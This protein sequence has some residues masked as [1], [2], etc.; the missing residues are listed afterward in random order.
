MKKLKLL[1]KGLTL[2][3]VLF[4]CIENFAAIVSDNDGSAFITKAEFDSLKNNF[5]SQIDQYNTSI[6]AKIDGAIAAY[7]AG[8]KLSSKFELDLDN[9]C[10]YTFPLVML[11][12]EK[13]NNPESEYF[14]VSI[15]KIQ[16]EEH[17]LK[18][19][20]IGANGAPRTIVSTGADLGYWDISS[21]P[22]M[23]SSSESFLGLAFQKVKK[24]FSFDGQ[25]GDLN[26]LKESSLRR[27]IGGTNRKVYKLDIEGK[28][29]YGLVYFNGVTIEDEFDSGY[30]MTTLYRVYPSYHFIGFSNS[31]LNKKRSPY[32]YNWLGSASRPVWTMDNLPVYRTGF[33]ASQDH[34]PLIL[35][36]CHNLNEVITAINNAYVSDTTLY[37]IWDERDYEVK[38]PTSAHIEWE[39]QG[40]RKYCYSGTARMP[41]QFENRFNLNVIPTTDASKVSLTACDGPYYYGTEWYIVKWRNV[42]SIADAPRPWYQIWPQFVVTD[43]NSFDWESSD[44]F[45]MIRASCVAYNDKDGETHYMD[46]GMYL[47]KMDRAGTVYFT[48]KF[49]SS[50]DKNIKFAVSKKP[51]S[52]DAN[53]DDKIAFE[54]TN[55]STGA[56][57]SVEKG[58]DATIVSNNIYTI[59]VSNIEK[60]DRLYLYW[61]P[62]DDSAYVEL[63]SFSDYYLE[64]DN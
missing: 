24:N 45:S 48:I 36:E 6:D 16:V 12:D 33:S 8:V 53:N 42:N 29:Q 28:G 17:S 37:N 22:N 60:S 31:Q 54:Y 40:Q 47:G 35:P 63:E 19:K 58:N 49:N 11:Q 7:L 23:Y 4:L 25:V 39:R 26:I 59:K 44:D 57:G 55:S 27:N 61:E 2:F 62:Q 15:P 1:K 34:T 10:H 14:N 46:E 32:G 51:F 64:A 5:Q 30:N 9:N 52:F 43:L 50:G 38:T 56:K 3:L 41:A 18:W 20:N 21:I 13:W